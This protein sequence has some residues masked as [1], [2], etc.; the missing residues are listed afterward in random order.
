MTYTNDEKYSD[1]LL[2]ADTAVER[3]FLLNTLQIKE[4]TK[5][6]E[7]WYYDKR[8]YINKTN[9][10]IVDFPHYSLHDKTHSANILNYI[11]QL[12]GT[13]KLEKLSI[14]DLWLLLQVAYFHDIGMVIDAEKLNHLWTEDPDF[15]NFLEDEI[16]DTIDSSVNYL[17]QIDDIL[18]NNTTFTNNTIFNKQWPLEVKK[19]VLLITA[20]YIRKN[21]GMNCINIMSEFINSDFSVIEERLYKIVAQISFLHTQDFHSIMTTLEQEEVCFGDEY[22]HPQFIAALLRIGDVLDMD[23]NRFDEQILKHFGPLPY[24]SQLHFQKHKSLTNFNITTNKISAKAKADDIETCNLL[25]DWFEFLKNEN[26]KLILHWNKI[27]P[28]C[29]DG[30]N[31]TECDLK[32]YLKNKEYKSSFQETYQIDKMYAMR[33]LIGDNLYNANLDF[34]R[35]YVQNALDATK[36]EFF[37]ELKNDELKYS[38]KEDVEYFKDSFPYQFSES[39]FERFCIDIKVCLP[40]DDTVEIT[41]QDSGIGIPENELFSIFTV[42][43]GWRKRNSYADRNSELLW[44]TRTAG[45][46]IGIQAVFMIT[47]KVKFE[48][49][50]R[51]ESSGHIVTLTDPRTNGKI[52]YQ[53]DNTIKNG[54]LV[55][56]H[57][58]LNTLMNERTYTGINFPTGNLEFTDSSIIDAIEERIYNYLS[59]QI[60]N[61]IFPIRIISYD[62][63][64]YTIKS[65]YWKNRY[66]PYDNL[67]DGEKY[68]YSISEDFSDICVIN[69]TSG[70]MTYIKFLEYGNNGKLRYCYKGIYISGESGQHDY[71]DCMIDILKA[72][73]KDTLKMNRQEFMNDFNKQILTQKEII[74]TLKIFAEKLSITPDIKV[75]EYKSVARNILLSFILFLPINTIRLTALDIMENI[76]ADIL[77]LKYIYPRYSMHMQKENNT[78]SHI[79]TSI[80]GMSLFE[81]LHNIL[82]RVDSSKE[83]IYFLATKKEEVDYVDGKM[84]FL[85]GEHSESNLS[86]CDRKIL[87]LIKKMTGSFNYIDC[88]DENDLLYKLLPKLLGSRIYYIKIDNQYFRV[89]GIHT[90]VSPDE[91][92]KYNSVDIKYMTSHV[93]ERVIVNPET[94][95]YDSLKVNSLPFT[96][97]T[98]NTE[99]SYL[100]SPLT[101]SLNAIIRNSIKN[102]NMDFETFINEFEK[103]HQPDFLEWK[104]LINWVYNN[105][106]NDKYSKEIIER[107]Y[108]KLLRNMYS[109]I[110]KERR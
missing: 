57:I 4:G 31:L 7:Q 73:V 20:E 40:M 50:N 74:N 43:S 104:R 27:A 49:K 30:C 87:E 9:T 100:I 18:H 2:T 45:F 64:V 47:D 25:S 105:Q 81:I 109:C 19:A 13:P 96:E 92:I 26:E 58:P 78:I 67:I 14:G 88:N 8:L 21:H 80:P 23:N 3:C 24:T 6:R 41:I 61:S 35:E 1:I 97:K 10:T 76:N 39:V 28:E 34:I 46:G 110:R 103:N 60:V 11:A 63:I 32:V 95:E 82:N 108:T 65:N 99:K 91:E 86:S 15:R 42:G 84:L 85:G 72:D 22:M 17:K 83:I 69:E 54:T 5:I 93:E 56:I 68:Y 36:V 12:L 70:I 79:A 77:D 102:E 44:L 94:T 66:K 98:N 38:M 37:K 101:Y 89:Y 71:F 75:I 16:S 90:D 52:S 107:D 55:R 59:A 62:K 53:E 106:S 51:N 29:V 33:L 48:T